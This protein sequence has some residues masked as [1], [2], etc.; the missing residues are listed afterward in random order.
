MKLVNFLKVNILHKIFALSVIFVMHLALLFI[1]P[2]LAQVNPLA[3]EDSDSM[4]ELQ[5]KIKQNG[6]SFTVKAN[7]IYN[8]PQAEKRKTLNGRHP[9]YHI[10]GLREVP[11]PSGYIK[12]YLRGT[13]PS[14]YDIRNISGASYIGAIR[15]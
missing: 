5:Q 6:Y 8:L 15:N 2:V 11:A 9:A 12:P 13:L 7:H 10:A 14:S 1:S 4:K 3:F